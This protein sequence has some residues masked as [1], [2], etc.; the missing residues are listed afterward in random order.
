MEK[1][2]S[3]SSSSSFV[4]IENVDWISTLP[5]DL[6]LVILSRLS[7]EEAVRTSVVSKRW[8]HV[9]KHMSHIALDM[10]KKVTS[11]NNTLDVTKRVA[12]LMTKIINNHRGHLESCVIDSYTN[13][14]LNTWIDSLTGVRQTK[15]LTLRRHVGE[16]KWQNS[17]RDFPQNSFSFASLTSLSLFSYTLRTS[18]SFND[19]QNLKTLKLWVTFASEAGIFNRI[20]ASCPSLEVLVLGVGCF[21]KGGPLKI[22]NKRLKLLKVSAYGEMEGIKV[23]SPSL[24]ILAIDEVLPCERYNFDLTSPGL[25]FSRFLARISLPHVSYNISKEENCIGHEEYVIK[26]GGALLRKSFPAYMSVSVDLM[27]AREVSRLRQVLLAWTHPIRLELEIIF[28]KNNAHREEEA[29][30]K[31]KEPF[32]N[33]EFRVDTL[34]M[35]NFSG[36]SEEE[37]AFVSCLVRQK[38]VKRRMM[39]KTTGFPERN[40]LEIETA[41]AKLRAL[42]TKDQWE[43]T[44]NCF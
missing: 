37:F 2:S 43:L 3:S 4:P 24:H 36:S 1:S 28:K 17:C 31:Y 8:E 42:K 11:S 21:K 40:K 38:T 44:I 27:N 34:W 26:S 5:N 7:T 20:L 32:P 18:H 23:T 35:Y 14:M 22:D 33:A 6:L 29:S 10:R 13:G 39:I 30:P 12:P 25:Q 19:C 15:H 16:E 9:W 41:V